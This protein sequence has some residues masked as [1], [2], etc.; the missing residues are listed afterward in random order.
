M[1]SQRDPKRAIGRI[2]H[3]DAKNKDF[4]VELQNGLVVPYEL[5]DDDDFTKGDVV[6][7]GMDL[8][9]ITPGPQELWPEDRW[10][11]VVRLVLD[12]EVVIDAAG[13]IRT[14]PLPDRLTLEKGNTVEGVDAEIRRVISPDPIRYIELREDAVTA[15]HFKTRPSDSPSFEDFGGFSDIVDRAQELIELP[16]KHH[17]ELTR[18]GARPIK[19]VLFTGPPGTGK[20]MLARIIAN[21][22]NAVFYEISGPEVLSKWYGQS[23]E[24]IRTIFED[25]AKQ[26]RAIVFFDEMDSLASQRSDSSH[27]A[28]RRIV[29]QLLASMDGFTI[30]TNVVVIATTNRPQDIDVALRRPGRFD[31]EINF[32]LPSLEDREV[33]LRTSARKLNIQGDMPHSLVAQKTE[34]WSPAELT[35]IWSEA[36]LLAVRDRRDVILEEDYFGG[37]ERVAA[38]RA[39]VIASIREEPTEEAK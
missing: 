30:D 5:H 17:E 31:W 33:I 29:G 8:D 20:T 11:G 15:E 32:S 4:I 12:E 36:A 1:T 2:R 6:L 18:I 26:D 9:D 28:T 13:R 16:L 23:E 10:I 24:V 21:R 37:F 14:L 38:Q 22:A 34:S 19:G 7:L 3:V 35:A 25:A 27:E 39:R